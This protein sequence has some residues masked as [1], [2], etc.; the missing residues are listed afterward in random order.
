MTIL[1][2]EAL[3]IVLLRAE[4]IATPG[5]RAEARRLWS[6]RLQDADW[7]NALLPQTALGRACRRGAKGRGSRVGW[8]MNEGDAGGKIPFG[9]LFLGNF[10]GY[11]KIARDEA[12][13]LKLSQ[14]LADQAAGAKRPGQVAGNDWT[15]LS[16]AA[17]RATALRGYRR[18]R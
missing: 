7:E 15:S 11:L 14:E 6:L 9:W 16:T 2:F 10:E 18:G 1:A 4:V 13:R 17:R 3:S 8:G 5:Y 12:A